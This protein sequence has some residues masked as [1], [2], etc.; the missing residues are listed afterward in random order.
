MSLTTP[1]RFYLTNVDPILFFSLPNET[2]LNFISK[3]LLS[4]VKHDAANY[5]SKLH[6][7][8]NDGISM[9]TVKPLAKLLR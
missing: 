3:A 2:K 4:S 9:F 7:I 5:T 8:Q 1:R 6:S